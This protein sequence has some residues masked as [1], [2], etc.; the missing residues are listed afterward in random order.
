M[1]VAQTDGAIIAHSG[2]DAYR[3]AWTE[4]AAYLKSTD[5]YGRILGTHNQGDYRVLDDPGLLDMYFL[6]TGHSA[7]F[8]ISAQTEWFEE[9]YGAERKA[10]IVLSEANYQG[11]FDASSYGDQLQRHQFWVTFLEGG[12]GHT[13]G[14]N[15]IWPFLLIN[16]G[17]SSE[18]ENLI[19]DR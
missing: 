3:A 5:P 15:G 17:I 11:L 2:H 18:P 9:L 14:G 7:L 10:P 19:S 8:S 13:Y 6:Q 16:A 4:L 1:S 12:A